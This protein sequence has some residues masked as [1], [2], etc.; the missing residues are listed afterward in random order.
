M[1][2]FGPTS[3]RTPRPGRKRHRS[4][5]LPAPTRENWLGLGLMVVA[6]VSMPVA[7]YGTGAARGLQGT[8]I[9]LEILILTA[10]YLFLVAAAILA[11]HRW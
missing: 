1:K 10:Y 7:V 5:R 3:P 6:T 9:I 11:L 2:S 4:K 8:R